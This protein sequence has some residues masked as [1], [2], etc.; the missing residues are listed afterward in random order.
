MPNS[1]NFMFDGGAGTFLGTAVAAFLIT[2]LTLGIAF[3][4]ID[5]SIM[6]RLQLFS[7]FI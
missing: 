4:L 3:I 6:T 1:K 2:V 5:Y 7:A